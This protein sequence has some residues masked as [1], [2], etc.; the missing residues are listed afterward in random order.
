MAFK[1]TYTKSSL[2]NI[3]RAIQKT[4]VAH[5]AKKIMFDYDDNGVITGLSFGI[6]VNG[7]IM[8]IKLP[9]RIKECEHI[10]RQEGLLNTNKK[11]HALRVAW[12]NI[13]DWVESQMAMID[14]DMV[15]F[16]EVFLPYVVMGEETL[17]ERFEKGN[18]QLGD[19]DEKRN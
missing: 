15:K 18:L 13:R 11:D 19:G 3:L 10:L 14:I 6:E 5:K 4:L 8:G 17:F 9:A 2:E 16:E 12:A 7:K 1:N